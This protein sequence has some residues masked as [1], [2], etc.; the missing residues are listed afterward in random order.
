M[1]SRLDVDIATLTRRVGDHRPRTTDTCWAATAL[2]LTD[3]PRG[4]EVLMI[5]RVTRDGDRWSGDMALPGGK[6]DPGDVSVAHTAAREAVEE[7][8]VVVSDPVGRLDDT[9]G[10]G[11][12]Q[13]VA[14]VVFTAEGRP[15][16]VPE[17]GEVA[18][19]VWLPLADLADPSNKTWYRYGGIVPFPSI[20]VGDYMIWGLTHRI[21][22]NFFAVTGLN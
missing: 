18:E 8:Q 6:A 2:I 19:A 10:R 12:S 22:T 15:A 1:L 11:Y 3:G 14:T 17:P 5:R 9:G 21:L 7:T 16:P 20:T 4:P 13:T